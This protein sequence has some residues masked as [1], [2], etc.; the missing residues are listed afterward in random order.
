MIESLGLQ[1]EKIKLWS[2]NDNAANMHAAIRESKYLEELNTISLAVSDTFKDVQGTNPVF[3]GRG[4]RQGCSLSPLLFALYVVDLSRAL[5]ESNLGVTLFSVCVSALFFADDFVLISRTAEGLRAL[6]DIV[7]HHCSLLRMKLSISK[8]KVM[9]NTRDVWELFDGDE[10]IGCL[11]KV[12]Q[13]KY[14]GV[15]TC[16]SHFKAG[17]A[18]MRRAS[19]LASSYRAACIRIAKDGPD[20]VD[21]AMALWV[22]VAMPS[23]LFGAETVP[24]SKQVIT[25][26]SRHQSSV[27]KFNLGLPSCSPNISASIILGLKPFKELLYS[28]QLK[29]YVRL[30][31]QSNARWSK[32]ALL[33]NIS[34]RWPS[35]YIKML[36]GIKREV[37]MFRWPVSTRHVDIVL[38]HHFM[39]ETNSEMQRLHLPA[40]VPISK[41]QR[42]SHVNESLES[43]VILLPYVFFCLHMFYLQNPSFYVHIL[44]DAHLLLCYQYSTCFPRSFLEG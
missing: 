28:A 17:R 8:S 19:S 2:I 44:Q 32:D 31:N 34:G 36:S 27:G 12:L 16:L 6:H 5:I 24:F 21:L 11:D 39:Q 41:R 13:F 38:S 20:I 37:G 40:L 26:I 22:N 23:L 35:P 4:L 42:M 29:F 3:L 25:E 7:L 33:D 30:S 1:D 9:S 18:M 43:Q 14:L 15:E 10:I